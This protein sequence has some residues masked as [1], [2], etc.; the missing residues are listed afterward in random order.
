MLRLLQER[1]QPPLTD[2]QT[3]KVDVSGRKRGRE[4]ERQTDRQTQRMREGNRERRERG[5]IE[6]EKERGRE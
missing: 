1:P 4:R 5:E 2:L 6:I 3:C